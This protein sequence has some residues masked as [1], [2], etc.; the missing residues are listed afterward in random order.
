MRYTKFTDCIGEDPVSGATIA[1]TTIGPPV[2]RGVGVLSVTPTTGA[3]V[4]GIEQT[5]STSSNA[6]T[7]AAGLHAAILA[8]IER[9]Y[10]SKG[11]LRG[12]SSE[13]TPKFRRVSLFLTAQRQTGRITL[14]TAPVYAFRMHPLPLQPREL[15]VRRVQEEGWAKRSERSV[16]CPRHRAAVL[17]K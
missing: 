7:N 17:G 10:Q 16:K 6:E 4:L 2:G 14:R 11:D 9:Y 3:A 13:F 1:L 5:W 8:M 15:S 12:V